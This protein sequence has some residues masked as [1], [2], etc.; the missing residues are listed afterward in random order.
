MP[1]TP[2]EQSISLHHTGIP[3]TLPITKAKGMIITQA[4]IPNSTTQ[5]LRTGSRI[6]PMKSTAITMCANASQSYP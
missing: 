1:K 2:K 5:I 3:L 6:T 4:I